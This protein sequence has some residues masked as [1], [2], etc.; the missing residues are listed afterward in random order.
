VIFLTY[1]K[2]LPKPLGTATVLFVP[3]LSIMLHVP[4]DDGIGRVKFSIPLFPGIGSPED[5]L[6]WEMHI[7]HI[8]AAHHYTEEK[9]QLAAIKFSDYVQI[10]WGQILCVPNRHRHGEV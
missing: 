2:D 3:F 1:A 6:E 8:F 9:L 5:Y 4:L 10:W 7:S